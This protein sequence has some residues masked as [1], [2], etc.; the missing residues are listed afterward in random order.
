MSARR[1]I[2]VIFLIVCF[3]ICS[4]AAIYGI[5]IMEMSSPAVPLLAILGMVILAAISLRMTGDSDY[6]Q[7][8]QANRTLELASKTLTFM[9]Q[10]LDTNSAQAVCELLLPA[11][12]SAAVAITD[13]A[14]VLGFSGVDAEYHKPNTAVQTTM[15]RKTLEDGQVRVGLNTH[16]VG[17]KQPEGKLRAGIV[18]PLVV[19]KHIVG[20]LKFYYKSPS[21]LNETQRALVEGLATLL[22]TQ[23]SL[24]YLQQQTELAAKMELK[25]L[26]AQI[27]PHFLFNTINTIAS[28]TRSDPNKARTMLREFAVYYRRVLENSEDLIP[29]TSEIEQ[30]ER[31][32]I[33]QKARFGEDMILMDVEIEPGLEEL[34]VPSFILQPLVENCV[35]HGRR[36]EGALHIEVK[37]FH[38]STSV[39]ISVSDDGVGIA[40]ERIGNL[41]DAG[42]ETGMGIALKNVNAR[43]KACFGTISGI[44]IDSEL[45]KGTTVYLNLYDA[46][47]SQHLLDDDY[48][49]DAY[50][51]EEEE[52]AEVPDRK[53][54]PDP[55]AAADAAIPYPHPNQ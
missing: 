49:D 24:S 36:E 5:F 45:G 33:F 25:A 15:T 38:A 46:L 55:E 50:D 13:R 42:S 35:S 8:R 12:G 37:V 14:K 20:T 7:A 48:D 30:T 51:V 4:A 2:S 3:C 53:L 28:I 21:R 31:Y 16:D 17:F 26:Q 23:V 41:V 19:N 39:V 22:S 47:A 18:A 44:H 11:C 52:E 6:I 9:R 34:T 32:L 54:V 29:I 1:I 40:P 43:I 10:G 27:N